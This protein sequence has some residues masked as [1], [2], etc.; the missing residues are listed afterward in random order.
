M[1]FMPAIFIL[2]TL[3]ACRPA[4]L[5]QDDANAPTGW[6]TCENLQGGVYPLTGGAYCPE[7]GVQ[8]REIVLLSN[9]G[10]MRAAIEEAIRRYDIVV[11]DGA[12]GPFLYSET[13]IFED[14]HNKT[15]VGIHGA[16]VQSAFRC[17]PEIKE[18]LRHAEERFDGA[19]PES[20]GRFRLSNDSLARNFAGYAAFQTL[21][22]L[23][24]DRQLR[25]KHCGFWTFRGCSNLVIRNLFFDGPGAFRGK[26]DTMLRLLDGTGHV[27]IDHCTFEDPGCLA[28]GIV[29]GADCITASWCRFRVTPQSNG[30]D[31]GV[32]IASGDDNWYDEDHLNVTFDHC[33]WENVWSRIP[34]ARFGSI[35]ILDNVY[36][37][38]GTV[39]INP[40]TH[41]EFLVE[42]CSFASGTKPFCDYRINVAPPK[43]YVFRNCSWDPQFEVPS[44]GE[45]SVPYD[46]T[47]T[48]PERARAEVCSFAGP[49]LLRPLQFNKAR[50]SR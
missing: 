43:A 24:G 21:L 12:E 38:P 28:L 41:A 5:S 31:L 32:L 23:T 39:G 1:K 16:V 8:G 40:R 45:V 36:D 49:T 30:H 33:W 35:H 17:T 14:L 2:L 10:D 13:S 50:P 11:L 27:W 34:M 18:A 19:V 46:Y 37:C 4:G 15:I 20:N 48:G 9:G 47:V 3:S 29:R 6:A 7:K 26:P 25:F 44:L 42:G 22:E